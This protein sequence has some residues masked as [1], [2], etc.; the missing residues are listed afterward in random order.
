MITM[1]S[2]IVEEPKKWNASNLQAI[3]IGM[4]KVMGETEIH[5]KRIKTGPTQ[6]DQCPRHPTTVI[7]IVVTITGTII[8]HVIIITRRHPGVIMIIKKVTIDTTTT[9]ILLEVADKAIAALITAISPVSTITRASTDLL[10]TANEIT[11]VI[12]IIIIEMPTEEGQVLSPRHCSF[13]R[14]KRTG[15]LLS[16][17]PVE[18]KK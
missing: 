18:K 17:Y 1:P 15:C 8:D 6:C 3:V 13:C 16:S 14:S 4:A 2:L 5:F 12:T 11:T 10:V 7:T 9:E